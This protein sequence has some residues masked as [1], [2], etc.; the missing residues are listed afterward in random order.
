MDELRIARQLIASCTRCQTAYKQQLGT[1]R[2]TGLMTISTNNFT[3]VTLPSKSSSSLDNGSTYNSFRQLQQQ[4][5]DM[6]L[7]DEEEELEDDLVMSAAT[8]SSLKRG[9]FQK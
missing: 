9:S 5:E 7:Q 6:D 8:L 1:T 3:G 2:R 4:A